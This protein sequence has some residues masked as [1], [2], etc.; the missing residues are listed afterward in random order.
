MNALR[1]WLRLHRALCVPGVGAAALT[2][3]RFRRE[4]M[5]EPAAYGVLFALCCFLFVDG[6]NR[7]EG[8]NR[9]ERPL[10][11]MLLLTALAASLG[12]LAAEPLPHQFL[13][14][15]FFGGAVVR[16]AGA[17]RARHLLPAGAVLTLVLPFRA[18][19]MLYISYPLRMIST[20]LSAGVLRC[21]DPRIRWSQTMIL[22]PEIN[23]AITDACSGIAQVEAMFLLSYLLVRREP[24]RRLWK[25]L[26]GL[27]L[28]P[29]IMLANALRIVLTAGVHHLIGEAVFDD[30][31]HLA[32][33]CLQVLLTLAIF[34][35]GGNLLPE[36]L[37]RE[38]RKS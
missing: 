30:A 1:K 21:F 20:V 18:G 19:I 23:L 17:R 14:L 10:A 9:P 33:G 16:I 8:E 24:L 4:I 32:L 28:F 22:L 6:V 38:V 3:V 26:H 27:F 34:I 5:A 29:A 25:V 31:V 15:L 7:G 35:A 11:W 13:L 2:A 37:P 12:P 36:E